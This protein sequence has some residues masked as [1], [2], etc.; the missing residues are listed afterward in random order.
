MEVSLPTLLLVL[1]LKAVLDWAMVLIQWPHVVRSF[2]GFF[3][4]SLAL[5][6]TILDVLVT[7]LFLVED[8][9][10]SNLHFTRYHVCLLVQATGFVYSVLQ[11]PVFLLIGLDIYRTQ[12]TVEV[13]WTRKLIYVCGTALLWS[14]TMFYVFWRADFSPVTGDDPQ[15][16]QCILIG[17]SQSSQVATVV[18]VAVTGLVLYTYTHKYDERGQE[19]LRHSVFSFLSNWS[20]FLALLVLLLMF[21]A[22]IPAYLDM[23][24]PW[25][26]LLHSFHILL[27][28]N[29]CSCLLCSEKEGDLEGKR[30]TWLE[31][32]TD[33]SVAGR[34]IKGR[35][36][37]QNSLQNKSVI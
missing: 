14:L 28:L 33:V 26:D 21:Q 27:T 12:S 10:I 32:F 34:D 22:E 16:L 30:E 9:Y 23:N 8:L 29:S 20:F 18:L 25:L 35:D 13:S 1:W 5:I 3:C 37:L 6:D 11:W 24:V 7:Q 19:D 36:F 31:N 2:C 4:I 15:H 17:S